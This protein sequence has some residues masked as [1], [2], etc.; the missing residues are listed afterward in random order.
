M[1]HSTQ[2][3]EIEKLENFNHFA[4]H[5]VLQNEGHTILTLSKIEGGVP[6]FPERFL[7]PS[8]ALEYVVKG[9]VRGKMNNRFVELTANTGILVMAD[10]V[11]TEVEV[12]PD[13][14]FYVLGFTTQFADMLNVRIPQAVLTNMFVNPTWH[15]TE[16]QMQVIL[17]YINLLRKLIEVNK[18]QAIT[19]LVRSMLYNQAA[20]YQVT[21]QQANTISRAEQICGQYLSLVEMHCRTQHTV[22]WYASQMCLA[23]KYLS[24]VVKQTLGF[25]PNKYIDQALMRQ[26]KS[27]LS[28]TSL[29]VQQIS[30]R[31]GFQNQSHF[32][33]F[34]KRQTGLSPKAF[35]QQVM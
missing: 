31:L 9:T 20:D 30:D 29:S 18:P 7:P 24:N 5:C 15:M 14:E 22:E 34:F 33:T 4:W 21:P 25:S 11:L 13:C 32:G 19:S 2:I 23:P 28:S 12:S 6:A 16:Q 26:A 3:P 10:H 8:Y 1:Q 17:Q 27:L 35:K